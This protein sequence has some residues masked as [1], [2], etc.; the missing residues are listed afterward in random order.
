MNTDIP[1]VRVLGLTFSSVGVASKV[2]FSINR[3]GKNIRWAHSKRLIP[4]TLVCLSSNNFQTVKV[5]TVV[6]RPTE[7]LEQN[8]PEVDLL[9]NETEV[10]IDTE[11]IHIMVESRNGYFEAYKWTL[12]ALQRMTADK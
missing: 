9:F 10:E 5:A 8:P 12:R 7:G 3:A 4:G 11:K 2:S 6:A 1:Q